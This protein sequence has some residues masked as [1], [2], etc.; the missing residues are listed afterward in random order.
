MSSNT[1]NLTLSYIFSRS[2]IVI[3]R[4]FHGLGQDQI[5]VR[6]FCFVAATF[7]GNLCILDEL[8]RLIDPR[9]GVVRCFRKL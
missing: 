1:I 5:K 8:R 7:I 9:N 2:K 6:D 3:F 4:P